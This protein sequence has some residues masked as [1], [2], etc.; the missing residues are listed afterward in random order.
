MKKIVRP[1]VAIAIVA[2]AACGPD[3]PKPPADTPKKVV[4]APDFSADSA[5]KHIDKQVSFGPRVPNT[6]AHKDCAQM[7][8]NELK[9]VT[10]T[11]IVQR[12]SVTAPGGANLSI[13]NIIGRL[14]PDAAQR[15]LLMAHWDTRNVADNDTER[16]NEPILGANDGA[17]GVGVLIELARIIH[18]KNP[19]IGVD[20]F[21]TDAEDQG[22]SEVENSYCLGTQY[23]ASNPPIPFYKPQYAILLDMVGGKG[24]RFLKEEGSV[25][26][27]PD[28]VAK[29]WDKAAELGYGSFFVNSTRPA[30][31][32]DHYY[33]NIMTS[34]PA[35]DIIQYGETD[36]ASFPS[37][38]HT[39]KDNMDAIDKAT[40]K[41]VGQTLLGVIYNENPQ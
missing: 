21:F 25:N 7:L 24:A 32:D 19:G 17:S 27:A 26:K 31:I 38:W 10:D 34:I 36:G 40:L 37:Y 22:K 15:I 6:Q 28:V 13:Y 35:I 23:W 14:Y 16:P 30:I 18:S 1:I 2:I 11:V 3:T 4:V 8:I 9:K 41:A 5:Y 20:I 39:H 33:V 12:G 29:V